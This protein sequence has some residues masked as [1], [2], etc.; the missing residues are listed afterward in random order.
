MNNQYKKFCHMLRIGLWNLDLNTWRVSIDGNLSSL[1][2]VDC[3]ECSFDESLG[4]VFGEAERAEI[5]RMARLLPWVTATSYHFKLC[6][7]NVIYAVEA[8][9]QTD[10]LSVDARHIS[11]ALRI[12]DNRED[13][14]HQ[15]DALAGQ[16]DDQTMNATLLNNI[17]LS[18]PVGIELY[19]KN[20]IMLDLNRRAMEIFGVDDADDLRG[21]NVFTSVNTPDILRNKLRA[22]EQV[23]TIIKYNFKNDSQAYHSFNHGVIDLHVKGVPLYDRM[24]NI[25]NYLLIYLDDTEKEQ[26]RIEVNDFK[27]F[28]AAVIGFAN[29]GYCKWDLLVKDGFAVN[30]WYTNIGEYDRKGID[31][32][33]VHFD[34]VHPDDRL[35]LQRAIQRI[36]RG[37]LQSFQQEIRVNQG[38][39]YKWVFCNFV[40]TRYEPENGSI[41]VIGVNV[42]ISHHKETE[43]KLM[44]ANRESQILTTQR[45]LVM[46][47]LSSALLYINPDYVVQWESTKILAALCG[48]KCFI[49]G[50]VC[51]R[52]AFNR[53]TPCDDCPFQRMLSS[54]VCETSQMKRHNMVIEV[55]ANPVFDDEER[56]LGGVVRMD[57][58]TLRRDNELRI[59]ELSRLMQAILD[60]IP[61]FVFVKNPNDHFKYLYWNKAMEDQLNIPACDVIGKMDEQIFS[62]TKD[63][64]GFHSYDEEL[65][66]QR[67]AIELD[68]YFSDAD[69]VIHTTRSV[70]TLLDTGEELP[71]ILGVSWDITDMRHK[72]AEL[73]EAK[74]KAEQSDKFKST[75]LANMSHEIR[76][77]LNAIIGFSELLIDEE[78]DADDRKEYLAILHRNNQLLLQLISDILDLSKIEA[79]VM[80]LNCAPLNIKSLC[81]RVATSCAMR[82]DAK[83]PV[84]FDAR[85]P[86]Y[87][88]MGDENRIQQVITNFTTNALKFTEQ[89]SIEISYTLISPT[90]LEISV[91]DTGI[92]IQADMLD[93][94]FERFQKLN[95]LIQGT[96][97]GLAICKNLVAQFGGRIGVES[98]YGVGSRFWFTLPYDEHS[99]QA[100]PQ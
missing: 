27:N 31:H 82:S 70:K 8:I 2:N 60:N 85:L 23:E 41:E 10:A 14:I 6:V 20:G 78:I 92:G 50:R 56:L 12:E 53:D 18:M 75:F 84:F 52:T 19:D 96:G 32:I 76:T 80:K 64:E 3:A 77:P 17:Y 13:L 51:Y 83:V 65:L 36:K 93:T 45:D 33:L 11:G 48:D 9:L 47:N 67:K 21:F 44:K 29:V 26:A 66:R 37:E 42:E 89:G 16:E 95:S 58:I 5:Q 99:A 87:I 97:L 35:V 54:K 98:E 59:E 24:N 39:S 46:N 4:F 22:G 88:I 25:S 73:V 28:F 61:V 74:E 72:E 69:G 81:S 34:Y 38:S 63:V 49:P 100:I 15:E 62:N 90:E 86:E 40:V 57:D 79:N 43:L 7:N 1:L 91:R 30:Q 55:V 68:E 71:L 94:I